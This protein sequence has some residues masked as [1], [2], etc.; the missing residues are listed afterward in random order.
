MLGYSALF[1]LS[2]LLIKFL[3]TQSNEDS[4]TTNKAQGVE[5]G[6]P[7]NINYMV[8]PDK[9]YIPIFLH[10]ALCEISFMLLLISQDILYMTFVQYCCGLLA[11]LR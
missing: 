4:Y 5:E 6:I 8:D 9:Y 11:S 10:T 2:D 1:L 7:F 3:P